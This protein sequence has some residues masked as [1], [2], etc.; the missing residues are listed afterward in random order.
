MCTEI[1]IKGGER[2]DHTGQ[3]FSLIGRENAVFDPAAG[4]VG[5]DECLCHLDV[6]ATAARA[7]YSCRSGWDEEGCD[8][9]WERQR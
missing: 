7:G 2:I 9:I 1:Q 4:S 5:T 6:P 3:L 8:F